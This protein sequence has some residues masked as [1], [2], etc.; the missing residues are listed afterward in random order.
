[1]FG[2]Y[3]LDTAIFMGN[4]S[5]PVKQHIV[6]IT[7]VRISTLIPTPPKPGHSIISKTGNTETAPTAII[8]GQSLKIISYCLLVI[9]ILL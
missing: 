1:M 3:L 5:V 9:F 2:L 7:A 8:L 6:K 4:F